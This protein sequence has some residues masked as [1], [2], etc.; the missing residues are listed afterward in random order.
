MVMFLNTNGSKI[1]FPPLHTPTSFSVKFSLINIWQNHWVNQNN[2]LREIKQNINPWLQ[3]KT[4]RK[5]EIIINRLRIC[6]TL[7]TH[8]HLVKKQTPTKCTPCGTILM[9][10]HLLTECRANEE[11]RKIIKYS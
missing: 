3:T 10:K 6:H 5:T 7:L 11:E 2:K 9:L 4:T 8:R 1:V